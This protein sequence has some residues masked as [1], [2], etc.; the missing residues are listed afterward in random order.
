MSLLIDTSALLAL[1][2]ADSGDHPRTRNVWTQL[3]TAG[4]DLVCTSY[5][6]LETVALV[7][8]RLG[9]EAVRALYEDLVPLLRIVWVDPATHEIAVNTLLAIGR[10]GLSLV[11]CA[12]FAVMRRLGLDEAFTLD[13]DFAKQGFRCR[14]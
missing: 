5:V 6:L 1:L 14:P 12:S 11:D 7:Q 13:R 9:L 8:K 4:Q 2:D 10:R 3:V